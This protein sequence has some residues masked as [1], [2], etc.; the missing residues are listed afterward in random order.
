M[1]GG[2]EETFRAAEGAARG[3]EARDLDP[4]ALLKDLQPRQ[5]RAAALQIQRPLVRLEPELLA[6]LA[7]V[8]SLPQVEGALHEA[9]GDGPRDRHGLL[10]LLAPLVVRG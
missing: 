9:A 8:A 10:H 2:R 7:L 3:F 1:A 5:V 6:E 4:R